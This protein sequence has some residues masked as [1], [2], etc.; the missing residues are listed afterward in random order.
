MRRDRPFWQETDS[1]AMPDAPSVLF[2]DDARMRQQKIGAELRH[3]Y[4]TVATEP[5]PDEWL[6]LLN[7]NDG[8]GNSGQIAQNGRAGIV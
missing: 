2:A 5:V 8:H 3:W 6:Q 1:T 4:K 7:Q